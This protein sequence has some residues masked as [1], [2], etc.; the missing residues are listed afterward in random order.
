MNSGRFA[1][2]KPTLL[3][4]ASIIASH[5]PGTLPAGPSIYL[6]RPELAVPAAA[7]RADEPD[8]RD[9][10]QAKALALRAL[11]RQARALG[12]DHFEIA[13]RPVFIAGFRQAHGALRRVDGFPL[14][15]D[16]LI[17]CPQ[18]GKMSSTS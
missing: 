9:R 3:M 4:P 2:L 16:L 10:T 18:G 15:T 6:P 1:L 8:R 11:G 5:S 13:R 12:V 7:K 17:E 14:E